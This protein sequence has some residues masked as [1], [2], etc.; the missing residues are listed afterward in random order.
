[1]NARKAAALVF[2]S[3]T[4]PVLVDTAVEPYA[5]RGIAESWLR[6]AVMTAVIILFGKAAAEVL[7]PPQRG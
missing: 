7:P 3:A 4:V 2:L 6:G 5:D 1:M